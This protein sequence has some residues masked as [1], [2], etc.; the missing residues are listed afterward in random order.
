MRINRIVLFSLILACTAATSAYVF[1]QSS[2]ALSASALI[3]ALKME[4]LQRQK[5]AVFAASRQANTPA[6]IPLLK[7]ALHDNILSASEYYGELGHMLSVPVDKPLDILREIVESQDAYGLEVALGAIASSPA[8][9][10]E[11]SPQERWSMV[12]LLQARKP[13]LGGHVSELGFFDVFAYQ[14]WLRSLMSL[15]PNPTDQIQWLSQLIEHQMEDPREVIAIEYALDDS[16]FF[17]TIP[18]ATKNALNKAAAVYVESYPDNQVATYI[19]IE[20]N[21]ADGDSQNRSP[22]ADAST[23]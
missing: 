5:A 19:V 13:A 4:A 7:K 10:D 1:F 21:Q 6:T 11:I 14:N 22:N 23:Q 15:Q 9:I 3:A 8:W 2:H 16:E 20:R 12:A 17:P 18:L